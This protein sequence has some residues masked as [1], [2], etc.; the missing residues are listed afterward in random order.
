MLY[1]GASL[2]IASLVTL[3]VVVTTENAARPGKVVV[4][5]SPSVSAELF[6]DGKSAGQ[7]PP[8][9]HT[10]VAGK[11]RIEVRADGYKPFSTQVQVPAGGRPLQID[12][13][14]VSEG[15]MQVEG[16]VLTQP[17]PEEPAAK[18]GPTSFEAPK[19]APRW[20][21]KKNATVASRPPEPAPEPAPP[22]VTVVQPPPAPPP[23]LVVVDRQADGRSSDAT[24]CQ[25]RPVNMLALPSHVDQIAGRPRM[26]G[27][28]LNSNAVDEPGVSAL[29]ALSGPAA[30][31]GVG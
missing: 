20:W 16:M 27:G 10:I 29:P 12:A 15:P 4:T 24:A 6:I 2:V 18:P 11:H 5:P 9:V 21:Q 1:G 26:C 22:P 23:S 14:L 17:R 13:Q 30:R 31:S 8:F 7:L 19:K 3:W 28:M 25:L